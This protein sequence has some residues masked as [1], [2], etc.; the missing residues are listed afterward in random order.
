MTT[1]TSVTFSDATATFYQTAVSGPWLP[2]EMI[3]GIVSTQVNG[4]AIYRGNGQTDQTIEQVLSGGIANDT[5]VNSGGILELFGG[6]QTSGTI[7]NAGG[8]LEF[9]SGY[10]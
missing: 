8:I 9:G 5:V 7:F 10:T 1:Y 4:W 3:D 6:A 2:S